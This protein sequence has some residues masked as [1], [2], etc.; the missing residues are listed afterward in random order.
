MGEGLGA[1]GVLGLLGGRDDQLDCSPG[2]GGGL[3]W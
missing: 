2:P 3:I 1:F